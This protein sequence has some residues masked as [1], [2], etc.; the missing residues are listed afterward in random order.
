MSST[1]H[2]F[3]VSERSQLT[4]I[5]QQWEVKAPMPS[6][7]MRSAVKQI[8]KLHES[9]S[10]VLPETQVEV[11]CQTCFFME[12]CVQNTPFYLEAG[13]FPDSTLREFSWYSIGIYCNSLCLVNHFLFEK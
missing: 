2:F 11:T 8:T 6:Q 13:L 9:L 5:L 3:S 12:E 7:A 1:L 10:L 4:F